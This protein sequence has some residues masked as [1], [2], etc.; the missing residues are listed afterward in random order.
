M[1]K[2][3][4]GAALAMVSAAALAGSVAISNPAMAASSP[5]AACGGGSYRVI[6]STDLGAATVYLMWNG[7][8]NCAVTWKDQPNSKFVA[9]DIQNDAGASDEDSG[10]YSTYA[11]PVKVYGK[12]RCIM[13]QGAYGNAS[14]GSVEWGHCG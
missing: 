10:N 7:T 5:I 3:K 11:G 13:Y 8:Y 14:G 6:S 2:I 1:R 9:V 4:K 12:G